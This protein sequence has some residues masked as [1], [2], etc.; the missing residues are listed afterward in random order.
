MNN[1]K[2]CGDYVKFR[3]KN[4]FESKK[5]ATKRACF[6]KINLKFLALQLRILKFLFHNKINPTLLFINM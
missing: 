1:D 4:I 3:L 2:S 6:F 5:P